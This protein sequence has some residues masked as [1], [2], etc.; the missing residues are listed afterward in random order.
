MDNVLH[1]SVKALS[2]E[3]FT[4]SSII[5]LPESE[6]IDMIKASSKKIMEA[7]SSYEKSLKTSEVNNG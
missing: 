5:A 3:I 7:Y 6:R 4:I 2:K 1:E